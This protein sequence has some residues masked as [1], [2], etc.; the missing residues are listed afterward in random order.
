MRLTRTAPIDVSL[1]LHDHFAPCSLFPDRFPKVLNASKRVL[2]PCLTSRW[3]KE[4]TFP[5]TLR[6]WCWI[7]TTS[8]EHPCKAP[9]RRHSLHA[10]RSCAVVLM[11]WRTSM[12]GKVSS[13]G[14]NFG[15]SVCRQLILLLPRLKH[16]FVFCLVSEFPAESGDCSNIYW[17]AAIFKVGDDVRQVNSIIVCLASHSAVLYCTV[18]C[19]AL[20]CPA[21][22]C[23]AFLLSWTLH[24]LNLFTLF[25][26]EIKCLVRLT[27]FL[28]S[29]Y[30]RLTSNLVVQEYF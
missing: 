13:R 3:R 27:V 18:L 25:R 23:P 9:Q 11:S 22:P 12:P 28:L 8:L 2:K 24:S 7:L 5:A 16:I 10:S 26:D 21:L 20:P 17:Q 14:G 1:P 6:H 29:G 19:P 4:S 15:E 30:A